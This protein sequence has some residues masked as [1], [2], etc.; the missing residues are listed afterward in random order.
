MKKK[1]FV[2]ALLFFSFSLFAKT[3]PLSSNI[4]NQGEIEIDNSKGDVEDRIHIEN[5]TDSNIS[6]I[7]KGTHKKKGIIPVASGFVPA[8]DTKF[9]N[10]NFEDD[11]DDFKNFI[12]TLD[13]GII[14]SYTAEMAW[15]DLYF[16]VNEVSG[17][18]TKE[19]VSNESSAD[20][21]TKWKKLL[22]S[23]VITQE[24]FNIKKKQLLGL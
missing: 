19:I 17:L 4:N 15:S 23:G 7:I 1:L 3:I 5:N 9:I 6:I 13:A 16:A 24:E 2:L 10:T 22:D 21:L 18:K 20:E 12:I 11:L 8:H 14:V